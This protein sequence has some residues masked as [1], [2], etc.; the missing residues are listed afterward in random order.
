MSSSS[1][2]LVSTGRADPTTGNFKLRSSEALWK[3]MTNIK[4]V[5]SW[6]TMS[7]MGVRFGSALDSCCIEADIIDRILSTRGSCC[8]RLFSCGQP[9][10]AQKLIR[11]QKSIYRDRRNPVFE[12]RK[13]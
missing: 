13:E 3:L 1:C 2:P 9:E 4:N 10:M 8:S 6:N 7:R 11:L 12:Y 5:M